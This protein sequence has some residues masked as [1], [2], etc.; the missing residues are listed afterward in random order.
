MNVFT[1]SP[2]HHIDNQTIPRQYE[3]AVSLVNKP[4]LIG[5]ELYSWKP[6]IVPRWPQIRALF[7]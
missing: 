4:L 3:L 5:C 1:R 2:R 7:R 6:H